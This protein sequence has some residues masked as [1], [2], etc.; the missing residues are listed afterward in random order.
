M[1][2]GLC[3][4]AAG[5]VSGRVAHTAGGHVREFVIKRVDDTDMVL[6]LREHTAALREQMGV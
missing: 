3:T 5:D 4:D 1:I 2:V 6:R